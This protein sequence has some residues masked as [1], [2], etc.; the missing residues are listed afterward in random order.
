[1]PYRPRLTPPP[2]DTV[3]YLLI[4]ATILSVATLLAV[5]PLSGG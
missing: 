1:M 4:A 2:D 5:F 3:R